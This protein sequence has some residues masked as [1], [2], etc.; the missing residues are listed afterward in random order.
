MTTGLIILAIAIT[1]GIITNEKE[2]HQKNRFGP[3][4]RKQKNIQT[5]TI[6]DNKKIESPPI[7]SPRK[8]TKNNHK[9]DTAK[10]SLTLLREIEWKRFEVLCKEL[11]KQKECDARL[12]KIGMDGGIDFYI[13]K[14]NKEKPT[15][16]GQ[17][18][19][20]K[21]YK[22]GVKEVR[23]L[24]GIMAAESIAHGFFLTTSSYTE[25]AKKFA[26]NIPVT[27]IDGEQ[28]IQLI[29]Q[30]PTEK[31]NQL[32]KIA[33]EGDYKTP[34]CPKCNIKLTLRTAKKGINAG[35]KFWG[36]IN[37]PRCKYTLQNNS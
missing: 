15:A 26:K 1:L 7:F 20:W 30:L 25:E 12:S 16:I 6:I 19:A 33:T 3:S 9:A 5:S 22:V 36:C 27:L 13:Y 32:L 28:M 23:E 8:E 11:F 37:Y 35:S 21:N 10:W 24:Y 18:K 2:T 34:T 29:E 4:R 14:N 17:C 31:Q